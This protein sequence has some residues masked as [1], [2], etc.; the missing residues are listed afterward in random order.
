MPI[1][2]LLNGDQGPS[3]V[4]IN[5]MQVV[6]VRCLEMMSQLIGIVLANHLTETLVS[7]VDTNPMTAKVAA[8]M[9]ESQE[10]INLLPT[11]E[12]SLKTTEES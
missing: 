9:R 2:L 8:K 5:L 6:Q 7:E 11:T 4:G 12:S 10:I 1:K 3:K